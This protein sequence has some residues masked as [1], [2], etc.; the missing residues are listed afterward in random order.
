MVKVMGWNP[1]YLC[2]SFPLQYQFGCGI[3][4]MVGPKTQDFWPK[5]K[6]LF[7]RILMTNVRL[8]KIGHNFSQKSG[9][10]IEYVDSWPIILLFKN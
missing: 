4:K 5:I 10:K 8:L 3:S 6:K 9:S 1:G 7:V 2:K